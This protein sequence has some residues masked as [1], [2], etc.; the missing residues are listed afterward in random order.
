MGKITRALERREIHQLFHCVQET[1]YRERNRTLLMCGIGMALRATELCQL[2]VG[3]VLFDNGEVKTYITIRGE[4]A[5]FSKGRTIRIGAGV[6]R[7]IGEF[8]AHK[9]SVNESLAHDAPLFYSQKGGYLDRTQLFRT[10]KAVLKKTGI[11][12]SVHTLRKTGGTHYY[13]QSG[14]DLI[15]TQ[16]FLGHSDPSTT[17]RYINLTTE[18]LERYSELFS[19][20]LLDAIAHE[21]EKGNTLDNMLHFSDSDLLLELQQRGYEISTLLRQKRRQELSAA[22]VISID[23]GRRR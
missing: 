20:F 18:Q 1:R 17:R 14:Y 6:Q 12:E 19:K 4:T 23:A 21:T 10:V 5:K 2:N 13:I 11:D 22:D 3:D 15:A 9:R 8:F 7:S 16:Q